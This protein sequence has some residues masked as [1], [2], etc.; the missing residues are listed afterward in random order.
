VLIGHMSDTFVH[1]PIPMA[2]GE[3]AHMSVEGELWTGVL[4]STGQPRRFQ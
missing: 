2:I 1:V 3:K 4:A